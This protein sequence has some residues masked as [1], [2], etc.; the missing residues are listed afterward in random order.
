MTGVTRGNRI[1]PRTS[2]TEST[3]SR[4][5]KPISRRDIRVPARNNCAWRRSRYRTK[6]GAVFALD[7]GA[8]GMTCSQFRS[9]PHRYQWSKV[10]PVVE[11]RDTSSYHTTLIKVCKL[12][13]FSLSNSNQ[14]DSPLLNNSLTGCA[15]FVKSRIKRQYIFTGR[16]RNQG[17]SLKLVVS[18]YRETQYWLDRLQV[19]LVGLCV[20]AT[21]PNR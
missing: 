17:R 5:S 9:R 16:E 1:A 6:T 12:R 8:F 4:F 13:S 3:V 15:S 10:S 20:R 11:V 21:Q 14:S 7:Q 19:F 2:R 18:Y